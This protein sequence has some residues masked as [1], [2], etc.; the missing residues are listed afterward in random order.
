MS[1]FS[2]TLA[3]ALAAVPAQAQTKA[4]TG[5]RVFDGTG[6]A[7]IEN[8]TIVVRD[9][10]ITA[11]GPAAGVTAWRRDRSRRVEDFLEA[12]GAPAAPG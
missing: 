5:A 2:V 12:L 1:T 4:F 7:P 10:R 3:F 11:V 8:A 6:S 9:G